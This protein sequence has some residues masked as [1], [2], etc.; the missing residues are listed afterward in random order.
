MI[1]EQCH[2]REATSH[3]CSFVNGVKQTRDLCTECLESSD[4]PEAALAA[5]IRG[6]RCDF[7]GA[8]ANTSGNNTLALCIG[9]ERSDNFCFTCAEEYNRY[10][11]S[12]VEQWPKDL[13]QQQQLDALRQL[14][15]DADKHMKDWLSRRRF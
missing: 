4:T 9:E 11:G 7:C 15:Q 10:T 2:Q 6:A 14:L 5:S 13:S 1:C 3:I 12:A 8:P